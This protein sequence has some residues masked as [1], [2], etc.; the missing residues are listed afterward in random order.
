MKRF[1]LALVN[2][3]VADG[4]GAPPVRADVGLAGEK[5]EVVGKVDP[6]EAG[7]ALDVEGLVVAPGFIDIHTHSD[8]TALVD[9]LAASKLFDGV[10]TEIAGNCGYSHFPLEGEVL[11]RRRE[12][13]KTYGVDLDWTDA[14]GFFARYEAAP[15]LNNRGF[16]VGQGAV[17]ASV[18][19]YVDRPAAPHE[20]DR[21]EAEVAKAMAAGALGLSSGLIYPPGCYTPTEELVALCR[22]ASEAGGYYATHMRSEGDELE[23]A[24]QE[25]IRIG[26]EARI[27]VQ[28]AHVKTFSQRNWHKIDWLERALHDAVGRG[29]DLLCDRYPYVAAATDLG[30]AMPRWVHDGGRAETLKRLADPGARRRIA[31]EVQADAEP[32]YWAALIISSTHSE[33]NRWMAGKSVADLARQA[34]KSGVEFA[35]DLLLEET[36]RVSIVSFSMSED[37]LRRILG[38]PFVMVAS[39]AG[40]KSTEGPLSEGKPHPR[41][42]GTF[43]RALGKY[44]R[45]EG[46]FSLGEAVRRMTSLPARRVGLTDR[47]WLKPG[48][49]ADVT[50][51]DPEAV[52]D[53]STFDEPH[54]YSV[55]VH[56]VVVNGCLA[57]SHGKLTGPM[58]GQILKRRA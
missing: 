46:V 35:M 13:L 19:G 48:F 21:M 36:C 22:V 50:V 55:G 54:Q 34:D 56:H 39:D 20:L 45:E 2:G 25:A 6:H 41:A 7:D 52:C 49:K 24:V 11:E 15:K 43:C 53:R 23:A 10:T 9:P 3:L 51:F 27:P 12:G 57:M 26:E 30:T 58:A 40:A 8:I 32:D 37:N 42:F 17:R 4:S 1:H 29:V 31:D 47:G 5:I 38:W 33:A 44:C 14:L 18:M 16:L 28:I